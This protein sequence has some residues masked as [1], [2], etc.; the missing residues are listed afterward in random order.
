MRPRVVIIEPDPADRAAVQGQLDP[1]RY[2]A[3]TFED[4]RR[5]MQWLHHEVPDLVITALFM[6]D[7]DGIEVV[8]TVKTL[9]D[10]VPI[11]VVDR[12]RMKHG[13]VDYLEVAELLGATATL[14]KPVDLVAL[15]RQIDE[16]LAGE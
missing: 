4:S 12:P 14:T 6:A 1:L 13:D 15:R 3:K 16:L 8:N 5:A 10:R 2:E 7:V 11:L 9:H